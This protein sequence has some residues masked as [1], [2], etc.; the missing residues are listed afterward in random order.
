MKQTGFKDVRGSFL[1]WLLPFI[2][3]LLIFELSLVYIYPHSVQI[4]W[5][6]YFLLSLLLATSGFAFI[7]NLKG[8]HTFSA[9]LTMAISLFATWGAVFFEYAVGTLDFFPLVTVSVNVVFASLLFPI[10]FTIMLS[11]VQLLSLQYILITTEALSRYS[12]GSFLSYILVISVLSIITSYINRLHII[13]IKENSI[14]DY[15]TGLYNRGYF[16]ERLQRKVDTDR[17]KRESFGIILIDVDNFKMYN[18]IYGHQP[19]DKLL[20]IISTFLL[21]Q[22]STQGEVYRYGG[23]EFVVILHD[24]T[25]EYLHGLAEGMIEGITEVDFTTY[26]LDFTKATLSMGLSLYPIHGSTKKELM[27]YADKNLL[28]SKEMGKNQIR[29]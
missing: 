4:K 12:W 17:H 20:Q 5:S 14:R 1:R 19:G 28:L 22:V 26:G 27:H 9:Y 8:M 21:D 13:Q 10:S 18:D 3:F 6:Y 7:A 24:A 11:I 29:G 25:S 15:L 23:D 16:E 2:F